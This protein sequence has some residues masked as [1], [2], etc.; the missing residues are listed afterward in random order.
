WRRRGSDD[1]RPQPLRCHRGRRQLLSGRNGMTPEV[2]TALEGIAQAY[3]GCR[4]ETVE[5]GQGGTFVTLHAVPLAGRYQQ[6]DPWVG[7][8]TTHPYPCADVSP[9]FVRHDLSRCD[10]KPLGEGT[11]MGAFRGQPA[12]QL[13][14]RANHLNPNTDTAL[15]KLFKVLRWL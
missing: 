12:V 3:P 11:G 13:S 15:L 9:H 14:R 8:Q 6:P 4:L 1:Y 10:G 2:R 7:F 5:D